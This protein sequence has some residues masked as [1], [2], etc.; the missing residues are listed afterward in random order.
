MFVY[1]Q[2]CGNLLLFVIT[3]QFSNPVAYIHNDASMGSNAFANIDPYYN[4]TLTCAVLGVGT[5]NQSDNSSVIEQA[6]QCRRHIH[7]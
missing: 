3:Y 5:A 1:K 7:I 2:R 6:C 4:T